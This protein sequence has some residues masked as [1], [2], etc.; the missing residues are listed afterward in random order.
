[1]NSET[2]SE[3]NNIINTLKSLLN[4][5][6]SNKTNLHSNKLSIPS[7]SQL[8]TT[9]SFDQFMS[10]SH[11]NFDAQS[12]ISTGSDIYGGRENSP[13]DLLHQEAI[14]YLETTLKLSSIKARAYK[15][16][17]YHHIKD[18]NPEAS[19][20]QRAQLMLDLIKNKSFVK[21]YANKLDETVKIIEE[22]DA[23]R[24]K[25]IG[26]EGNVAKSRRSSRKASRKTSKK[27]SKK[28]SKKSRR[29][30]KKKS[31]KTSRK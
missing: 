30:S 14:K 13:G 31:K 25:R 3:S 2:F 7:R 24:E 17:A 10:N 21:D 12:Y 15:S 22:R 29:T 23:E 19:G 9:E 20:L 26:T 5:L 1:M 16:I 8:L 27:A 6:P 18:K 11:S 28:T 4:E